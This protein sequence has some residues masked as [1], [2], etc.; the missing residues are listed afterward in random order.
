MN[1]TRGGFEFLFWNTAQKGSP[2]KFFGT[3]RQKIFDGK[4]WHNSLKHEIFPYPKLVTLKGSPSKFF[5]TVRQKILTENRGTPHLIH[6]FFRYQKFCETKK[7]WSTKFFGT[8]RQKIFDG[9][10][11]YSALLIH[12][13]FR[14]RN[15][16]ETQ[17][18]RIPLR[19]FSALWDKSFDRKWWHNL[20][21]HK[22]FRYQKLVKY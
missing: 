5:G 11:W 7:D 6:K 21:E 9:N 17:L 15:F 4:S 18:W 22:I 2:T 10:S 12:K 19:N 1:G 16:S 8:V 14:S 13:H 3:V 20:L